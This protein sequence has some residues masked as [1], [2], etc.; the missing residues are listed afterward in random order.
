MIPGPPKGQ[1]EVKV[2][3]QLRIDY[4]YYKGMGKRFLS[5]SD[6]SLLINQ[7]DLFRADTKDSEPPAVPLIIGSYFHVS[8][9]EPHKLD[10]FEIVDASTRSTKIYKEA[11]EASSEQALLLKSDVEM[12]EKMRDKVL[13]NKLCEKLIYGDN[14]NKFEVPG[15]KKVKDV[16]FKGKA[17][18]I[19]TDHQLIVDLK[20]TG[21]MAKFRYSAKRYGYHSQA[22]LY[23]EIFGVDM[24]FIVVDKRTFQVGVYDCSDTFY[25]AGELRV[26][27]AL[28]NYNLYF[29]PNATR[30]VSQHLTNGT[31][32]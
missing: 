26:E 16:W 21:D 13:Q 15:I 17:D 22:Y 11:V 20:T 1:D 6:L 7:P 32:L 5:N 29:G 2:I 28:E 31:L 27:Q 19:N 8:I 4:E 14:N 9:L 24:V 3:D 30:D 10:Q 23:R 12:I 18:I 25:Q